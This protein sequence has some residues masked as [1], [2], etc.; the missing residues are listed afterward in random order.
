[1]SRKAIN[2]THSKPDADYRF[3]ND[4][5]NYINE[6]I[7]ILKKDDN[8]LGVILFG[9]VSKGTYNRYSDIDLFIIIKGEKLDYLWKLGKLNEKIE[10]Q[11][12]AL[13]EAGYYLHISPTVFEY[14]ELSEFKPLF[15][16]I[17][18]YGIVLYDMEGIAG[19]F[20]KNISLIE[21][22]RNKTEHGEELS[23]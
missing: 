22:K 21:H 20:M 7:N 10:S 17:A 9:S 8:T 16:D 23:W 12:K 11:E 13:V 5:M 14:K 1:M 2:K 19:D 6:F 4:I 18:D 3:D 15:F